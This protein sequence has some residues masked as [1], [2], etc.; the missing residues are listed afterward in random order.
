M[1]KTLA[2]LALILSAFVA[3]YPAQTPRSANDYFSRAR[4][5]YEKGD[6]GGGISDYNRVIEIKP[7]MAEAYNNRGAAWFEKGNAQQAIADYST[8]IQLDPDLAAA[9][10]NR[11]HA[12]RLA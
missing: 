5:S 6:L 1:I 8:A 12:R 9:Y 7:Q 4:A 10:L 3:V 11:G 2:S